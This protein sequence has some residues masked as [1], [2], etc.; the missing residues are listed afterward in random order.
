ML[1]LLASC[2]AS[3]SVVCSSTES[4]PVPQNGEGIYINLA[5]GQHGPT[6]GSVPGF[7][8]NP[9]AQQTSTPPLQL[10]F[11]WGPSA[12]NGAGVASV[13]ATYAVL[14]AGERIDAN[15]LFTRMGA[16]GDTSAWQAGVA[17]GF[18]GVRFTIEPTA[19]LVYGWVRL[20][21]TAPL[22]FPAT[23]TDWCYEESGS[24]IT[25][26]TDTIDAVYC[27]GFD[28]TACEVAPGDD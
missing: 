2:V 4:I 16:T 24:G 9:Y 11:Y 14:G 19:T 13:G 12:N 6:E 17:Q 26:A 7:D 3:A 18:L 10:R 5:N 25:I 21:T 27:D 1:L 23:V 15:S 28:G 22:G 8:F 20:S